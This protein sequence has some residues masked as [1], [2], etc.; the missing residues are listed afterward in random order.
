MSSNKIKVDCT[1]IYEYRMRK[2]KSGRWGKKKN[3]KAKLRRL[4]QSG[5]QNKFSI[6]R[7]NEWANDIRNN[8]SKK[9]YTLRNAFVQWRANIKFRCEWT[10]NSKRINS[11]SQNNNNSIRWKPYN[12]VK[13]RQI[14]RHTKKNAPFEGTKQQ[15]RER[16]IQ[17]EKYQPTQLHYSS[18]YVCVCVSFHWSFLYLLYF[19]AFSFLS[20]LFLLSKFSSAFFFVHSILH[21]ISCAFSDNS[22][23]M[24]WWMLQHWFEIVFI[25]CLHSLFFCL[26]RSRF[27]V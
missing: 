26:H 14:Q 7:S 19:V 9:K 16:D 23:F 2:R 13:W 27:T 8:S 4:I 5:S 25:C 6:K 17:Q 18:F 22:N 24:Y 3:Q 1:F 12:H 21:K 10:D 15:E 20:R 11:N